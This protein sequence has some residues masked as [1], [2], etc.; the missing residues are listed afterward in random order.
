MATVLICCDKFKGSAT[1]A[2][3]SAAL[4]RGLESAGHAVLIAPLAD[5]GDGTLEAFDSLGFQR[6][7]STITN[8]NDG[9][10]MPAQ[11]SLKDG[12]AV[13]EIARACGLDLASPQGTCPSATFARSTSSR[14][15]GELILASLDQGA[16][17]IIIG[18]GGSATTDAGFGM[19]QALEIQFYDAQGHSIM[20]VNDLG[21]VACIDSSHLD[22][23]IATTEFVIA[24]DVSNPLCGPNGAAA[25][26]GPQK[27]LR[28]TD[29]NEVNEGIR[30][31]ANIL[32]N[33]LGL[34]GTS[35]VPGAGAAG[36]L[37]FMAMALLSAEMQS[38]VHLVLDEIGGEDMLAQADLLITGEGRIDHQTLSGK[39]PAGIAE[40]ARNQKVPI[41]VIAVCGQNQ[42]ESSAAGDLFDAIYSLTEFEE[43][44]ASCISTPLPILERIGFEIAVKHLDRSSHCS[45]TDPGLHWGHEEHQRS[46][47]P[48]DLPFYPRASSY[49]RIR[50]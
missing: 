35:S 41:P 47:W 14:G 38:G 21:Q 50:A 5:G 49:C 48:S 20:Q 46:P 11:F 17:R 6:I 8:F 34:S 33:E 18:L 9:S 30:K 13:I 44:I 28:N 7:T 10:T 3:V 32:E 19:A 42:L 26:Y 40:L 12:T 15:V 37:G 27:G 25:V 29:I 43:D 36:G 2:E 1:S 4:S 22:P 45:L 16:R 39:A 24:S 31:F 23:R